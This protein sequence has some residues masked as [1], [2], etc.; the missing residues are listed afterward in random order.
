[1][2]ILQIHGM[3]TMTEFWKV[4]KY[5][6][7]SFQ[8][9]TTKDYDNIICVIRSMIFL[10]LVITNSFIIAGNVRHW[11]DHYQPPHYERPE[12]Y[13]ERR[14]RPEMEPCSRYL[15]RECSQTRPC[16]ERLCSQPEV[17]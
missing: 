2:K 6:L 13:P 1:M 12:Q 10:Q 16:I 9:E 8:D 5:A 4:W 17:L 15:Y 3:I 14:P 7:G 11:N